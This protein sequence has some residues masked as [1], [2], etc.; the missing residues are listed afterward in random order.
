MKKALRVGKVLMDWSQ[1]DDHKTTICVYSLR[2]RERPTVSTPLKWDEVENCLKKGDPKLLVFESDQVLERAKKFG[3]LFEPV[4]KLKQKLPKV[5]ALQQFQGGAVAQASS[6]KGGATTKAASINAGAA[7]TPA[8]I[9]S[10]AKGGAAI[11]PS[12]RKGGAKRR[13][14]R[15][16]WQR[17]ARNRQFVILSDEGV[18]WADDPQSKDPT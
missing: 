11:E 16:A 10:R 1:N 8:R 4:L 15:R 17:N 6:A 7:A 2:A 9:R 13:S 3:D 18:R 5:E 12:A 14:S